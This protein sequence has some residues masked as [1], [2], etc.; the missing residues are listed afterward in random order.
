MKDK[1]ITGRCHLCGQIKELTYEHIPPKKA[2]NNTKKFIYPGENILRR[3]KTTYFPW[4]LEEF[5]LERIQKQRGIGWYTLCK[6]CN[7]FTGHHYADSLIN[8]IIQ[9]YLNIKHY[10]GENNLE[11]NKF[12]SFEFKKIKPLRIIKEIITMFFSINNPK[13]VLVHPDLQK[14]VLNVKKEGLNPRNYALYIYI[15]KGSITRYVGITG[16]LQL[17]NQ[18]NPIVRIVSELAAPPFGFVLE[19]QPKLDYKNNIIYFANKFKINEQLDMRLSIP[20]YE[21]NTEYPLDYRNKEKILMD[22]IKNKYIH[23]NQ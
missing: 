8:F 22:Y 1:P 23:F 21:S 16:I 5:G 4:Q 13:F 14:F 18:T 9:G 12:Y 2:F 15:L 3:L 6:K 10:G 11:A 19:M 7:N 20:V 17:R